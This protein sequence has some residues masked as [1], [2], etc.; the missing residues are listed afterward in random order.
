LTANAEI[1]THRD[2]R[3]CRPPRY[4]RSIE[5]LETIKAGLAPTN[6]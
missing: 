5:E 2:R 3:E 4:L 1:S 6:R